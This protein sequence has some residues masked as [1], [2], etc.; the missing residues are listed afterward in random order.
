MRWP[1][2]ARD[3]LSQPTFSPYSAI[4]EVLPGVRK[5]ET[6]TACAFLKCV[7]GEFLLGEEFLVH[8]YGTGTGSAVVYIEVPK[9]SHHA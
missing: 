4:T 1:R 5:V 9:I 6:L 8:K 3:P 7:A 2:R